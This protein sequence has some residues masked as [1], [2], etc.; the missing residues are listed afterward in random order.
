VI[1]NVQGVCFSYNNIPILKDISFKIDKAEILGIV[2]PNGSGKSTLLKNL[3][4]ILKPKDGVIY[5]ENQDKKDMRRREIAKRIAYVPQ[6]EENLFPTTVFETVLMGRKPHI[7]WMESKNDK[8]IVAETLERLGMGE[9][10]L[11]DINQLSGGERQK[12]YIARAIVQ[13]PKILLLDE[14]TANLDL[15]HQI[16]VLDLLLETKKEGVTIIIA[17]HDL[18]LALKYCDKLIILDKGKIFAYGGKEVLSR[19]NIETVYGV[20]VSI[21]RNNGRFY[22]IPE[23][24]LMNDVECNSILKQNE[25]QKEK[26]VYGYIRS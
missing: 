16:E 19:E 14:P 21:L 13:K 26:K 2:G 24:S 22:I 18:N 12:V 7:T 25:N 8:M 11:R 6:R 23:G 17:I 1:L 4:G 15:K 9:F 3:D 5:I 20:K 10:A